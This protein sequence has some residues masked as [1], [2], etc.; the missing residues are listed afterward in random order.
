VGN[1][2]RVPKGEQGRGALPGH[3][4]ECRAKL[5]RGSR[6]QGVHCQS[7]RWRRNLRFFRENADRIVIL[8]GGFREIIAPLAAHLHIPPEQV[9]CNDLL[10]DAEGRVAGVDERNP[11]SQAG[12]KPVVIRALGL[13]GPVVMIGDGWTDAEVRL[14]GAADR[15]HAF[16]EIVR[17]ENG[18][19]DPRTDHPP[20][21]AG[22][23][24]G[25]RSRGQLHVVETVPRSSPWH[26]GFVAQRKVTARRPARADDRASPV[27]GQCAGRGPA[28]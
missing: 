19:G 23:G 20:G 15:F 25:E 6:L 16:T 11:L 27:Q 26:K 24:C 9:L 4:I 1:G 13:P 3:R 17:R 7:Q 12:G 8:S 22:A 14:D 2:K 5:V 10:Y 28:A 18:D 21:M